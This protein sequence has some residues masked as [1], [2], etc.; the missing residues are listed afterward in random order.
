MREPIKINGWKFLAVLIICAAVLCTV[1]YHFGANVGNRRG[2]D[3][4]YA[5]G[6]SDGFNVGILSGYNSGNE[7]GYQ[8]GFSE[9]KEAGYKLGF[10]EGRE[11]GSSDGYAAGLSAGYNSGFNDGHYETIMNLDIDTDGDG[12]SAIVTTFGNHQYLVGING[13]VLDEDG[14]VVF[15]IGVDGENDEV[16]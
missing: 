11:S 13:Y 4:G 1:A 14:T 7:A 12:D 15:D 2:Y 5:A 6:H 10:D 3:S 16:K 9:G 8:Q